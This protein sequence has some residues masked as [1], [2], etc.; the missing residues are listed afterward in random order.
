MKVVDK[1]VRKALNENVLNESSKASVIKLI[2]LY[3]NNC[4][5]IQLLQSFVNRTLT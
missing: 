1:S 5:N 2:K 4:K 3:I